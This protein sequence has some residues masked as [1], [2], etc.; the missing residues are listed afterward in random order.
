[1]RSVACSLAIVLAIVGCAQVYTPT[2][3][4]PALVRV[5]VSHA[6]GIGDQI[7][8]VAIDGVSVDTKANRGDY[9]RVD[10]GMRRLTITYEASKKIV[11]PRVAAAPLELNAKL[12][13]GAKYQVVCESSETGVKAFLRQESN[14]RIVSNVVESSLMPAPA[15]Y[16]SPPQLFQIPATR[17][18]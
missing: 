6:F 17:R 5:P 12:E 16:P 4:D 18:R 3:R 10:P 14:R 9:L 15:T 2:S 7:N 8:L 11:G 13:T 1:M